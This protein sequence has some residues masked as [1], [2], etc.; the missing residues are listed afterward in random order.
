MQKRTKDHVETMGLTCYSHACLCRELWIFDLRVMLRL[1]S[2][3]QMDLPILKSGTAKQ[4]CSK[5]T[6]LS[7]RAKDKWVYKTKHKQA[8]KL[9]AI[10][11][12][13]IFENNFH[14]ELNCLSSL[15][16]L[17]CCIS[18][19]ISSTISVETLHVAVKL[20]M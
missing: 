14:S 6:A 17:K 15:W 20:V 5:S 9:I 10:T 13:S 3:L 1:C 2:S 19:T 11:V 16:T 18:K 4:Y 7:T 12:C 8:R